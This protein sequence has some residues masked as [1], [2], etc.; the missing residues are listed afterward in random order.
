MIKVPLSVYQLCE[1]IWKATDSELDMLTRT[2]HD[3]LARRGVKLF[4]GVS[5]NAPNR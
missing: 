4:D 2:C 3:V 5:T 1:A